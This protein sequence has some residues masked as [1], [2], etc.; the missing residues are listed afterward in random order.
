MLNLFVNGTPHSPP[1]SVLLVQLE[2]VERK[3]ERERER[4][5]DLTCVVQERILLGDILAY[6]SNTSSYH[7]WNCRGN[8][9][10]LVKES[11][12][13]YVVVYT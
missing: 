4:E 8:R 10:Y 12:P 1:E 9:L 3:R 5:R 7:I 2:L 13:L 6:F 11:V